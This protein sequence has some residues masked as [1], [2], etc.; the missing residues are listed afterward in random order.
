MSGHKDWVL[1]TLEWLRL[2]NTHANER[3]PQG[4]DISLQ[5]YMH[6]EGEGGEEAKMHG[7][8]KR[9]TKVRAVEE[10]KMKPRQ[11][12]VSVMVERTQRNTGGKKA[13]WCSNGKIR[14]EGARQSS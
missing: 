14:A 3:Q 8:M 7:D 1:C 5:T 10:G 9:H 4:T 6:T 11:R 12:G 2:T 13:D